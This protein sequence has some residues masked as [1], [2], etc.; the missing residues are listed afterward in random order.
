MKIRL[1][2]TGV[3]ALEARLALISSRLKNPN[4]VLE[5]L[6][7]EINNLVQDSFSKESSPA[8]SRWAPLTA[9][10]IAAKRRAGTLERGMLQSSGKMKK[11]SK[12]AITGKGKVEV[13]TV[14]YGVFHLFGTSK[15][16]SRPFMPLIQRSDGQIQLMRQGRMGEFWRKFKSKL[17]AYVVGRRSRR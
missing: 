9:G 17:A 16:P 7:T 11:R 2:V 8:G 3:R 13:Q 15:M 4:A 5:E 10:T 1:E 6:A 14:S 12:M